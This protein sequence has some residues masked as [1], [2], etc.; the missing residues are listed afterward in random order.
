[1][2]VNS[3]MVKAELYLLTETETASGAKKSEWEK[4]DKQVLISLYQVNQFVSSDKFRN[5]ETTHQI[6]TPF[7]GLEPRKTR[8][9]CN[10]K[11]FEVLDVDNNHRLATV[12][13]KEVLP[14]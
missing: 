12:S 5:T 14:W 1:M 4:Q 13:V 10:N 9:E 7:K 6:L 2:S 3:K 8:I 11:Y